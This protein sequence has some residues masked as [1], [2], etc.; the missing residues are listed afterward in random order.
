MM[1]L[2]ERFRDW[3]RRRRPPKGLVSGD[4]DEGERR[5]PTFVLE[6]ERL[7]QSEGYRC[8]SARHIS[9]LR[10]RRYADPEME[11]VL[12]V[13]SEPLTHRLFLRRC[14]G[15]PIK[16]VLDTYEELEEF[17]LVSAEEHLASARETCEKEGLGEM[18]EWYIEQEGKAPAELDPPTEP[19]T[20][21]PRLCKIQFR[22][23]VAAN[24]LH[25]AFGRKAAGRKL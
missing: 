23:H 17:E 10:D 16:M 20:G 24:V 1:R 4:L 7:A 3:N 12:Y 11:L 21:P 13:D 25:D 6:K 18:R 5:P 14:S 2:L 8:Y 15:N 22:A 19:P 9:G